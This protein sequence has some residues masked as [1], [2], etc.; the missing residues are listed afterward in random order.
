MAWKIRWFDGTETAEAYSN[1]EIPKSILRKTNMKGI[2]VKA[3][4]KNPPPSQLSGNKTV[5]VRHKISNGFVYRLRAIIALQKS[6]KKHIV[7]D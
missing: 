4:L 7:R 2:I 1:K 6:E 5:W 3:S